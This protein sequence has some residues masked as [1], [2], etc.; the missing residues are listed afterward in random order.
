MEIESGDVVLCAREM[1]GGGG[2]GASDLEFGVDSVVERKRA[3]GGEDRESSE[4]GEVCR[5]NGER[6]M[7]VEERGGERGESSIHCK[8]NSATEILFV[9]ERR[10]LCCFIAHER[11]RALDQS[12]DLHQTTMKL[13]NIRQL[14]HR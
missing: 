8:E 13:R 1:G 3:E 14:L 12:K 10:T 5:P 4:D 6:A 9:D 2:P 7:G 11:T